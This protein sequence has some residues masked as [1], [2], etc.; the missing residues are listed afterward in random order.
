MAKILENGTVEYSTFDLLYSVDCKRYLETRKSG[1]VDLT[2]LSWSDAW[3]E[4][5]KRYPDAQYEVRMFDGKPFLYDDSLGYMV[6]V[7]VTI[8]GQTHEMWLPVMDGANKSMRN[9][10]YQYKVKNSQFRYAKYDQ[11]T[12]QY[13]DKDGKVQNEYIVK[14]CEAATMSDINKT[15]MRC[16]VKGIAMFGLGLYVYSGEDVVEWTLEEHNTAVTEFIKTRQELSEYVDIRSAEFENYVKEQTGVHSIQPEI[17]VNLPGE[18]RRVTQLMKAVLDRKKA[19]A[20]DEK[21]NAKKKDT[22]Q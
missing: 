12:G 15:I 3:A 14:T 2:Y 10:P 21:K 4:V 13:V 5:C 1:N 7:D 8:N 17:L 18:M 6:F 9:E 22:G 20:K 16:L 19:D 11:A